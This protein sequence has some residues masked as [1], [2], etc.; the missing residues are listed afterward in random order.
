MNKFLRQKAL[1]KEL[2][3]KVRSEIALESFA[4]FIK[5]VKPKYEFNWHH[6]VLIDALERLVRREYKRLI[7]MMP[8]RH[9]KS[10][11][12]SVLFP[13]WCLARNENE[14]VIGASY[15]LGLASRMNRKCQAVIDS[16]A[17]K[18]YFPERKF[19][20][21]IR[22]NAIRQS[23]W[24]DFGEAGH[25]ISAGV[26]GGI[27]GEGCTI[28]LIDDPVKNSDEA[29]SQ[30]Y[31]EKN[32][33]WYEST[34]KTRFE[35][36]CVEVLCATRWH[37]DDLI[38]RV[39]A[40]KPKDT[41]IIRFPGLCEGPEGYRKIGEPI[42]PNWYGLEFMLEKQA[43][44]S[45]TWNAVYQQRPGAV[46]GNILKKAWFQRYDVR[47]YK[48]EGKRVCFYFDTA[49]TQKEEND[50]TAGIAYV[51][52][53]ADI[54]ILEASEIW[55]EFNEAMKWIV[56]FAK[57]NGYTGSSIIRIE[58]KATGL[59]LIQEIRRLTKLNVT[60]GEQ[61]SGDKIARAN[62]CQGTVEGGRVYLPAGMIWVEHFLDQV[63]S[64][65]NAAHDDMVDCLTGIIINEFLS[66]KPKQGPYS[67]YTS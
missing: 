67:A 24:F 61:P 56:E 50:P 15:A 33:E 6:L 13:A 40:T 43:G 60:E 30:T 34:F 4:E 53:G 54:Y 51:R 1:Q 58:P 5:L 25:Y 35:P 55:A 36:G 47:K 65:P 8:P 49:Y 44:G 28:G 10:E 27:T 16:K 37:E 17:F 14:R 59:S 20:N 39:L 2:L 7:V 29:D 46:E 18:K 57:R 66:S 11:L 26:G 48:L 22:P 45:R 64:F 62:K 23:H 32:W 41:E 19:G 21:E 63:A 31:R 38:G 12:V 52:E 3:R 42:W 9:G